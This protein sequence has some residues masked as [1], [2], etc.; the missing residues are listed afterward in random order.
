[1]SA[2]AEYAWG[3]PGY[4]LI[5][6]LLLAH[7]FLLS[8]RRQAWWGALLP[9][10]WVGVVIVSTAQGRLHSVGDWIRDVLV[11][12]ALAG[13]AVMGRETR[14]DRHKQSEA[15]LDVE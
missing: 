8:T 4:V 5:V 12:L 7:R 1:M 15:H 2:F 11:L 10:G 6:V 3:W 9:I 13:M 14:A